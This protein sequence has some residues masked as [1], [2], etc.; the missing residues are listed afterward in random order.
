MIMFV[1]W[2]YGVGVMGGSYWYILNEIAQVTSSPL[3]NDV[4]LC[5]FMIRR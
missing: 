2:V 1:E 5:L 3:G 4:S